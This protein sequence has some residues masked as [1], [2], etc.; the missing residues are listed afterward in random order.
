[1]RNRPDVDEGLHGVAL[2]QQEHPE[3]DR[4]EEEGEGDGR[5]ARE[6]P[7]P[8]ADR[9]GLIRAQPPVGL[10]LDQAEDEQGEP[11]GQRDHTR[12]VPAP[13]GRRIA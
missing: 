7:L 5:D 4:R 12:H 11:E 6:R 1:M 3:H 8:G 2:D 10:P 13:H 9:E